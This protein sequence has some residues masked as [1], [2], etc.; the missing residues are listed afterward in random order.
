MWRLHPQRGR[1]IQGVAIFDQYADISEAVIDRGILGAGHFGTKF[2]PNHR[3]SCVSSELSWF[4]SVPTFLLLVLVSYDISLS[5][6]PHFWFGTG[7]KASRAGPNYLLCR[8]VL[9]P[10]CP[11]TG[12]FTMEDEHE[13]VCAD[14]ALSNRAPFDDLDWP[15]T[16]VSRPQYSL[17][18]NMS[19]TVHPIHSTFGSISGS[20]DLM[21]L[22]AVR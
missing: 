8:G 3:W 12:I 14:C 18:A 22:F 19:Q 16:P 17:K 9:W 4:W 7:A 6:A 5:S 15:R 20:A 10:K 21:A 1:Q 11:V 2:K 13:V